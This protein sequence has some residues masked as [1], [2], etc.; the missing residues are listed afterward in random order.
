MIA[1]IIKRNFPNSGPAS[2]LTVADIAAPA[3]PTAHRRIYDTIPPKPLTDSKEFEAEVT[4]PAAPEKVGH[5]F[6][7]W[8]NTKTNAAVTFP[9]NMP[10]ENLNLKA[11][12]TK[13]TYT[14]EFADTNDNGD[15]IIMNNVEF[16]SALTAPTGLTK[17]GYVFSGWDTTP[18]A[19]VGDLGDNGAKVTYTAQWTKIASTTPVTGDHSNIH[20]WTLLLVV[21]AAAVAALCLTKR[22]KGKYVRR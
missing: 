19:T 1:R 10:A 6:A 5:V 12:W 13:E 17:T 20:M 9:F 15:S 18:P 3:R 14:I 22:P 21:S 8:T 4:A 7:G 16:G 11:G 2:S